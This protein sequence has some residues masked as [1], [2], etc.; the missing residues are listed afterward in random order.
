MPEADLV[1]GADHPIAMLAEYGDQRIVN[2]TVN[3]HRGLI[4]LDEISICG[5][6]DF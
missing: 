5:N 1:P 3:T 4:S 6:G 2:I